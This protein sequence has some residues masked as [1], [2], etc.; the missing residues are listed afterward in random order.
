MKHA[1]RCKNCGRLEHAD[2]AGDNE[3]PHSC[4]VCGAGVTIGFDPLSLHKELVA[5]VPA[6]QSLTE[7]EIRAAALKLYA[8]LNSLPPKTFQPGNWEV[9]AD[10][11]PER[12]AAL[13]LKHDHVSRH[14]PVLKPAQDPK[15][16][17][18]SVT[19]G[20]TGTASGKSAV[21]SG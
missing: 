13:G 9:L 21:V 10:A 11:T 19:D 20:V 6:G 5:L 7:E 17:F 12:L 8:K 1:F 2:H 15:N 18:R 3:L 4:R 16:V 14:K